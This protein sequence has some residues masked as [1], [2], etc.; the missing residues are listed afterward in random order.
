MPYHYLQ[1]FVTDF[2]LWVNQLTLLDFL[3]LYWPLIVIDGL[4]SATKNITL[5]LDWVFRKIRRKKE[6]SLIYPPLSLIIPARNEE[7]VIENSILAAIEAVYPYKEIIVVDDGSTDRTYEIAAKYANKGLIKLVHRDYGSGSKAGALNYGIFFATGD[8]AIA[9][10]AD[11]LIES[12]ALMEIVTPFNDPDIVAVSGNVRILRGE[13]GGNNLL[14]K[15]QAYEYLHSLELGRRFNSLLGTL[16]IISGAFGAFRLK[17]LKSLG[18]YSTDTIT[19]DFDLTIML[20]KLNKKIVFKDKAISWTFCPETWRDWRRQRIRWTRGQAETL[21]R[22]R[23]LFS[24]NKYHISY[25]AAVVDMIFMDFGLLFIRIGWALYYALN[26]AKLFPYVLILMYVIYLVIE[27]VTTIIAGALSPMKSD[28][29][30]IVLAPVMVLFY[31]PYYAVIRFYAY[32]QW[33]IGGKSRW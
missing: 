15:L 17:D 10:D 4:R 8:I 5:L 25:M 7:K 11:T 33:A 18:Q 21:W 30:K 19:E 32:L 14:V 2:C 16:L 23:N 26:Y 9:L 31:R 6:A 28:L 12:T 29:K 20:R 27:S 1:Q 3:L 22:H 24:R 13:K